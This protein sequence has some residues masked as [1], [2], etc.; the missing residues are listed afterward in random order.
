VFLLERLQPEWLPD[1][2]ARLRYTLLDRLGS[3]L[4]VGLF[5]ALV[6]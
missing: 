1:R 5:S 6:V 2:S 4:V 3:A